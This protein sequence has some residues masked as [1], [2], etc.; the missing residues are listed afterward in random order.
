VLSPAWLLQSSVLLSVLRRSFKHQS[1]CDLLSAKCSGVQPS[2]TL[3]YA[4]YASYHNATIMRRYFKTQDKPVQMSSTWNGLKLRNAT[5]TL[6]TMPETP[7]LHFGLDL[8]VFPVFPRL[9][10]PR[11]RCGPQLRRTIVT[12]RLTQYPRAFAT[13]NGHKSQS[14]AVHN[15]KPSPICFAELKI[16]RVDGR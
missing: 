15:W 3:I 16:R 13:G 10:Q 1:P 2:K 12:R 7:G 4:R 8:P 6:K 5:L 11:P 14:K 9:L